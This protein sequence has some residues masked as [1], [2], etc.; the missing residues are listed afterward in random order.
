MKMI[1]LGTGNAVVTKCY[2][3][4]F[5]L[6][7]GEEIF[8]VDGGGGNTILARL[9]EA[10]LDWKNI[11]TVFVTHKHMDHILGIFWILRMFCQGLARGQYQGSPVIYANQEVAALLKEMAGS[12][13]GKK[14]AAY[15][16]R[17]VKILPVEDGDK[18]QVL[19]REVT[20]FDIHSTKAS[21]FGF[22]IRLDKNRKLTCCGDEP[23]N[24]AEEPYARASAWLLHEAFCL[25]SQ[26]DRFKPYEKNHST[27]RD[28]A[29]LARELGV[30][31]LVLYH[32]EDQNLEQRQELYTAEAREE[33]SGN[34]YVPY[35]LDVLEL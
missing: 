29:R 12:L 1:V 31:N 8:L 10:G 15:L 6:T 23:Y 14:E 7:E 32:T 16:G 2:N 18:V 21:Q 3:T 19:G 34:I 22:S 25:Y 33:F 13:L 17:E 11:S 30:E 5:A 24:P 35:D 4:C 28:A 20:F 27:A 26:A 9:K